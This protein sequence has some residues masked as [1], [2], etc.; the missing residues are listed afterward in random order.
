[1]KELYEKPEL[2]VIKLSGTVATLTSGNKEEG[3]SE[4][5]AGHE[6]D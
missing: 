2:L 5:N 6:L 3:G 4:A 1:M